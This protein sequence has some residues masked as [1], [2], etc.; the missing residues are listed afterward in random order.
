LSA[1]GLVDHSISFHHEECGVV[2][3]GRIWLQ[4]HQLGNIGDWDLDATRPFRTVDRY[5]CVCLELGSELHCA[6]ADTVTIPLRLHESRTDTCSGLRLHQTLSHRRTPTRR[7]TRKREIM[8]VMMTP[9]DTNPHQ[10]AES[11]GARRRAGTGARIPRSTGRRPRPGP[12]DRASGAVQDMDIG[13]GDDRRAGLHA[14][15]PASPRLSPDHTRARLGVALRRPRFRSLLCLVVSRG[16]T[17]TDSCRRFRVGGFP[18]AT[19]RSA[20]EGRTDGR[21]GGNATRIPWSRDRHA[22]LSAAAFF[23]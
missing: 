1:C 9:T 23:F 19:A 12:R 21:G 4:F 3:S 2:R 22:M 6:G 15:P 11:L 20:W 17:V 5:I 14:R 7:V 18:W 16:D 10:V 8:V 13:G